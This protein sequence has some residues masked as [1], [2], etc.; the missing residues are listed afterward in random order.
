MRPTVV[1]PHESREHKR[2]VAADRILT[3]RFTAIPCFILIMAFVFLMTFSWL[4][5]F[6][7][8]APAG[9]DVAIAAIGDTCGG[10]GWRHVVLTRDRWCVRWRG[11]CY[12]LLPT[13][14]TLFFFLSILED[15]GYMARV[16]FVMDKPLRLE[17]L[18][19]AFR[20]GTQLR[21]HDRCFDLWAL[22]ARFRPLCR[23]APE[24]SFRSVGQRDRKMNPILPRAVHELWR[25]LGKRASVER[26]LS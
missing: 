11:R 6:V 16:A 26:W 7:R 17:A 1:R 20:A 4:G 5:H 23:R 22:A 25:L 21:V 24:S 3:G 2:S 18:A 14:V 15:S 8:L 10:A 12:R 13:I 19:W 9:I